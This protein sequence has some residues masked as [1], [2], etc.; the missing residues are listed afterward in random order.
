MLLGVEVTVA[1]GVKLCMTVNTFHTLLIMDI[2]Q[3]GVVVFTMVFF[4]RVFTGIKRRSVKVGLNTTFICYTGTT[5]AVMTMD[6]LVSRNRCGYLMNF[7][8][9]T[10]IFGDG[11]VGSFVLTVVVIE[12]VTCGTALGTIIGRSLLSFIPEVAAGT[13]FTP[14]RVSIFTGDGHWVT[15]IICGD[16]VAVV[17]GLKVFSRHYRQG[18]QFLHTPAMGRYIVLVIHTDTGINGELGLLGGILI[19][20][21]A[22][23]TGLQTHNGTTNTI[24]MI[25]VFLMMAIVT[26]DQTTGFLQNTKVCRISLALHGT[27][28]N[29]VFMGFRFD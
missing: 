2:H 11:R 21:G 3:R 4:R 14:L 7:T 9:T 25:H 19:T 1:H 27:G 17:I 23:N 5:A 18:V 24:N 29:H 26:A 28:S 8:V 13:G 16:N 12:N 20:Q 22:G 10:L 6:T 15:H